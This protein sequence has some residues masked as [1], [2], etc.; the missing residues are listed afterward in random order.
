MVKNEG[1]PD[2]AMTTAVH[3]M[4]MAE[5]YKIMGSYDKNYCFDTKKPEKTRADFE[6]PS[7][8]RGAVSKKNV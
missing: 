6:R 7:P 3:I 8:A 2:E 1:W 5:M 4:L